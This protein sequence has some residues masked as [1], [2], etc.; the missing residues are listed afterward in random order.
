MIFFFLLLGASFPF[1]S[2]D[3]KLLHLPTS[4]GIL[5]VANSKNLRLERIESSKSLR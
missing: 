5:Q 3:I 4:N 1:L 2:L